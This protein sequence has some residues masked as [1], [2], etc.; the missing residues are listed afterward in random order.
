MPVMV[1]RVCQRPGCG[2]GFDVKASSVAAGRGKYCSRSCLSSVNAS[3]NHIKY[4]QHGAANPNFKG[5]RSRDKR[6]YVDAFRARYPEKA[7]AHDATE[8]ALRTGRLVRPDACQR[9]QQ[10]SAEPLHSH[11]AD[12][13][14]PFAVEFL[15][16]PCHRAVHA[17]LRVTCP[18]SVPAS[19]Q[20]R[21]RSAAA[22]RAPVEWSRV[23]HAAGQG[24]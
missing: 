15:C 6:A 4:P 7:L 16:R 12:Y 10:R 3:A 1:S 24:L 9:C 21:A 8:W 18:P 5:W 2:R 19:S 14:K 20:T 13:S 11:H 23:G 17:K 22:H